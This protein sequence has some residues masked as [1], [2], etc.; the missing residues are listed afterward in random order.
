MLTHPGEVD[1]GPE[2]W[3]GA[4]E[5]LNCALSELWRGRPVLI[6]GAMSG[7]M[8]FAAEHAS[9]E[10]VNLLVREAGGLVCLCLPP[11]EAQRLDLQPIDRRG[12]HPWIPAFAVSIEAR[13]GVTTGIS[14]EDRAL[15]IAVAADPS[16]TPADLVSPGHVSPIVAD[17]AN[18]GDGGGLPEAAVAIMGLAGLRPLAVTCA[19][20]DESGAVAGPQDLVD[21]AAR[22]GL[23]IVEIVE[24]ERAHQELS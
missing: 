9:S 14:A 13:D 1:Q 4:S 16:A 11:E 22:S 7:E 8:V 17:P 18:L 24:V 23:A 21:L 20:L 15:T 2:R 6:L 12:G 5:G 10:L 19:V 3:G